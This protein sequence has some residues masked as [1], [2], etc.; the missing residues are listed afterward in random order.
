[1]KTKTI[2][3][4]LLTDKI[5]KIYESERI[6]TVDTHG[7]GCTLASAIAANLAQKKTF[8]YAVK[9]ARGYVYNAIKNS[10]KFGKGTGTFESLLINMLDILEHTVKIYPLI[11]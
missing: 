11:Y 7:S 4:V 9:Q 6:D 3:D 2:Y 1:M 5:L 10:V 8:E